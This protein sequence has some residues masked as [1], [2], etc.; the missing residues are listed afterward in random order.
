M[1]NTAA[2]LEEIAWLRQ[3]QRGQ[4]LHFDPKGD[5]YK[6]VQVL[7]DLVG[8]S[9]IAVLVD[10]TGI[11]LS[12][13]TADLV[14]RAQVVMD[15]VGAGT[16]AIAWLGYD[17]PNANVLGAQERPARE[18][19]RLLA[20]FVNGLGRYNSRASRT[21]I[22]H[23][24]GSAVVGAAMANG[25]RADNVI[26][27]GSPGIGVGSIAATGFGGNVYNARA[28]WDV[29]V[30]ARLCFGE[31]V[32]ICPFDPHGSPPDFMA[33]VRPLAVGAA[34]GHNAYYRG[35]SLASIAAVVDGTARLNS[36]G[37]WGAP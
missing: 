6:I 16:A 1:G 11:G 12:N 35:T 23:S 18:G 31:L 2:Q 15:A 30:N 33:G 5:D 25:L 36:A 24:Y 21:V 26:H 27:S 4:I 29:P 13:F 9:N 34:S 28:A 37:F 3:L 20:E 22:G 10:G 17:A 7:G 32:E 8:A 19:G 14:S